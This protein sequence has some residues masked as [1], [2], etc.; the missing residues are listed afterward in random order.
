MSH[1]QHE[2]LKQFSHQITFAL[3][4]YTPHGL[5]ADDIK[6]IIIAGL[7]GS[8]IGGKLA[9]SFF[10]QSGTVPIACVSD[11]ELP[12][13]AGND[14]LVILSSYSGNTEETLSVYEDALKRGC[15]LLALTSGGKLKQL[16]EQSGVKTY[17]LQTGFQ[18]R[19]AL[20]FS[21][22]YLLQILG[23]LFGSDVQAEL[24]ATASAVADTAHFEEDAMQV[25][26]S[27]KAKARSK[28]VVITDASYE[29]VGIRFCQQIQEN[30]KH[31]CF[32]HVIPEMNHNVI[33][34]YYGQLDSV[35]FFIH[36]NAHDRVASRFEFLQNLLEVENNKVVNIITDG[37]TIKEVYEV[38]YT[39]DW[40]SLYVADHRRVDSLNVPNIAS[41]KNFLD[42]V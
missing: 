41:L 3:Q 19:M 33:E 20:G 21:L 32:H 7:G 39:L 12:G 17:T 14:T 9:S 24:A 38:L 34:S 4:N 31:E 23:E 28:F 5:K 42:Q 8:G 30:A 35:Y 27:V 16:C 10:M 6:Q 36:A 13:Y 1:P 2:A 37:F 22:T 25:F 18:P 29:A 11:Y 26:N 15:K 40:L